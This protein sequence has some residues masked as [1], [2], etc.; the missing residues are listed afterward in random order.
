MDDSIERSNIKRGRGVG[1]KEAL[2]HV[3]LRM[4][5]EVLVFYKKFPNYTGKMREVLTNFMKENR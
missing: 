4:P 5:N 2:L 3:N 1:K